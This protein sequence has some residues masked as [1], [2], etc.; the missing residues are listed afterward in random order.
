M[1]SSIGK[2][3]VCF[4]S[5][6]KGKLNPSQLSQ[7]QGLLYRACRPFIENK[8]TSNCRSLSLT[9]E[10]CHRRRHGVQY[11]DTLFEREQE[12]SKDQMDVDDMDDPTEALR[13][14]AR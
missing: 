1:W 6:F 8:L 9:A 10:V 14:A 5:Y 3:S 4:G 13:K 2:K 11:D 12:K 7:T